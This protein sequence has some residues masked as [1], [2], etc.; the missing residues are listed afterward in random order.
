MHDEYD[1]EQQ[2][3]EPRMISCSAAK[4]STAKTHKTNESNLN[5]LQKLVQSSEYQSTAA[6]LPLLFAE[7]EILNV[8]ALV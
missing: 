6:A 7:D 4:T 5:K 8:F 1:L 3:T 2:R